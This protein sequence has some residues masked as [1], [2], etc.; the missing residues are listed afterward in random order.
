MRFSCMFE[1]LMVIACACW[2]LHAHVAYLW[3]KQHIKDVCR[4]K[5]HQLPNI[6]YYTVQVRKY[7]SL[8]ET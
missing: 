4:S 1:I 2:L 3:F 7:N 8:L 5:E 6:M